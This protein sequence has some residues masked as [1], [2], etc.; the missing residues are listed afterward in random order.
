MLETLPT[1]EGGDKTEKN[2]GY[3]YN[4]ALNKAQSFLSAIDREWT[5]DIKKDEDY[6]NN[7][8]EDVTRRFY[9]ERIAEAE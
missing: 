2:D 4:K 9:A 5:M 3:W 6:I 8:L 7:E 1:N